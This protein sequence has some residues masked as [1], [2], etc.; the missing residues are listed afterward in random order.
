MSEAQ[1]A[2]CVAALRKLMWGKK[3]K[4]AAHKNRDR[5]LSWLEV[6]EAAEAVKR[7]KCSKGKE[8]A[9]ESVS[10]SEEGSGKSELKGGRWQRG[11]N[12][13]VRGSTVATRSAHAI[14]V[15]G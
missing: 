9:A 3:A 1:F 2:K 15:G 8:R 11:F 12:S 10:E 5:V 14:G 13:G 6:K 7:A 4:V